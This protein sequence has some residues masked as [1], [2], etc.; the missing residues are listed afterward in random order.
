[1]QLYFFQKKYKNKSVYFLTALIVLYSL[2]NMQYYLQDINWIDYDEL[3][4][5]YYFPWVEFTSP[6]LYFYV[7]TYLFPEKKIN[8][9][10]K[11]LFSLFGL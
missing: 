2:N 11:W 9:K 5:S 1:V 4:K 10:S 3:F 8:P 7:V 6:L